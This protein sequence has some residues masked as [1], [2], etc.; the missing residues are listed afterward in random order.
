MQLSLMINGG[1]EVVS[2]Q[3][4]AS[5]SKLLRK[6]H[7]SPKPEA[8]VNNNKNKTIFYNAV[9][10]NDKR[11]QRSCFKTAFCVTFTKQIH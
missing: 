2:K 9:K 7:Y 4:S 6:P 3:P 5:R 8:E 10:L 1:K 11:W